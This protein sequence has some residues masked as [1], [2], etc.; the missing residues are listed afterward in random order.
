MEVARPRMM[1]TVSLPI[2]V[3][4]AMRPHQWVK[5]LFVLAPLVFAQ[6]ALD[7]GHIWRATLA[8]AVFSVLSGCVYILNDLIDV[9]QDRQHPTKRLRPIASGALPIGAAR[10]ALAVLLIGAIG[11]SFAALPTSFAAVGLAYFTL[12]VAYSF[13]LKHVPF[14]DVICIATGFLLRIIGGAEAVDVPI[15]AWILATTFLLA[16]TLA[17]GKRKHEILQGGE[18]RKE[19]R[20]VLERYDIAH[21][22]KAMIGLAIATAACYAAYTAFGSVQGRLFHPHDL[23]WTIPFVVFG[24]VRFVQLTD[25]AEDGRSPTDMMLRDWPF[26]VNLGLWSLVVV[27]VIYVR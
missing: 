17:L 14:V 12:N 8:F 5:N 13:A 15:T 18:R 23:A 25:R 22:T 19:Q 6:Q 3:V 10:T 24:L 21:V 11:V 20:K 9:E 26:L 27:I 7:L 4:R 2:A 1:S 16:L